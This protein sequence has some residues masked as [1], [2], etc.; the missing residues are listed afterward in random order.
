MP[1]LQP[2]RDFVNGR[3]GAVRESFD[4][5]QKLVL[6]RLDIARPRRFLAVSQKSADLM[7]KLGQRPILGCGKILLH[8]LYRITI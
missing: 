4:R 3:S 8:Y 1:D 6:L 2:L 7:A 5:Q